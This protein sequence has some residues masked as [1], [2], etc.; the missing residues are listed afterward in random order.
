M[1]HLRLMLE[2]FHPWTNA[3]GFYVARDLGFYRDVDLDV[4]ITVY[5][6]GIGDTLEYLARG[7]VD[8]G[9]FPTNRLLVR[10]EKGQ[11]ITGLAAINHRG[12]ETVQTLAQTGIR[13]PRDLEGKRLALNPTP[14]G[15][16]MIRHLVE[17]D[18]GNPEAVTL[19]D[20][21]VRELSVDDIAAGEVDATFGSYWAWDIL[22]GSIPPEE[23]V[24]W[25]VD[26]VGNLAYHSYLL[27]AHQDIIDAQPVVIGRF[28]SATERGYLAA[29]ANPARTLSILDKVIPY[30]PR[31]LLARSLELIAPTWL[32]D[33][34]WGEQREALI[35]PYANWLATHGILQKPEDWHRAISNAFLPTPTPGRAS[36]QL[37]DR[38]R[39]Q[40]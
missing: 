16:A 2:Y 26:E 24:V 20:A 30:F 7:K 12:L 38:R 5:D 25:P 14:R 9:V 34:T 13:R 8:F 6:P 11:P 39:S 3:A 10:R 1:T 37:A 28:L 33:G 18:G 35:G 4:E 27:G 17:L 15:K 32:H 31:P 22:F 21:G 40:G 23:R 19:V 29:V 36:P